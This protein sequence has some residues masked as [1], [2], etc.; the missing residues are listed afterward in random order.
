M[1]CNFIEI[2]IQKSAHQMRDDPEQKKN[3]NCTEKRRHAINHNRI[4]ITVTKSKHGCNSSYKLKKC[5]AWCMCNF[6]FCSGSDI[7]S[8]IPKTEIMLYR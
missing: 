5:C 3:R 2:F 6:Q 1:F 8:R 7:F 4:I